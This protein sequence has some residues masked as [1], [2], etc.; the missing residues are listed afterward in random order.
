MSCDC[1]TAPTLSGPG[2]CNLVKPSAEAVN[3]VVDWCSVLTSGTSIVSSQWDV[4]P[5]TPDPDTPLV[6]GS[7]GTQGTQ[8]SAI[9]SGGTPEQLYRAQ[10]TI[11]AQG[12]QG[13][14]FTFISVVWVWVPKDYA[15][16]I[17]VPCEEST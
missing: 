15:P 4:S 16:P 13:P 8:S 6:A 7:Q 9:I 3:Q 14:L 1:A 17:H 12:P 2:F 10:N 5:D 11:G